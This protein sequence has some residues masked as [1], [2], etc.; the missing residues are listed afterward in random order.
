MILPEMNLL[1]DTLFRKNKWM[2]F[3]L[4]KT[5]FPFYIKT[6]RPLLDMENQI[7]IDFVENTR[8]V[9]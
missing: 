7:E 1:S 4:T 8:E 3:I 5:C 2:E 9:N 6:K